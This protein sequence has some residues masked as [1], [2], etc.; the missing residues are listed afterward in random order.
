MTGHV[1]TVE[2]MDVQARTEA[3][4]PTITHARAQVLAQARARVL[5]RG[6]TA[7]CTLLALLETSPVYPSAMFG[8]D[9]RRGGLDP[10]A[11]SN[12]AKTLIRDGLAVI[13]PGGVLHATPAATD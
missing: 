11:L 12:A 4:P 10:T 3:P 9:D 5:E 13:T 6:D 2:R 8:D 7:E 1:P